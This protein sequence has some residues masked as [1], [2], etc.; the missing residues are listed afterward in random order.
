MDRKYLVSWIEKFKDYALKELSDA[1]G[2]TIKDIL[3]G[4]QAEAIVPSIQTVTDSVTVSCT[5]VRRNRILKE[6]SH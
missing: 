1:V 2:T 6:T 3:F 4:E 5:D